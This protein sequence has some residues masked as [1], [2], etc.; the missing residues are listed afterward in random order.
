M[1]FIFKAAL[2][3]FSTFITF[4]S[5]QAAEN[6]VFK[7]KLIEPSNCTINNDQRIDIDFGAKISIA[8]IDGNNYREPIN[9]QITCTP[10]TVKPDMAMVIMATDMPSDN[11]A[12]QTDNYFLGI[13]LLQNTTPVILNQE[14]IFDPASP[15]VLEAVPVTSDQSALTEGRFFASATIKV[16]YR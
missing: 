10:G 2:L 14:I 6:M 8:M 4:A 9:Y 11:T 7:G 12:I 1:Q 3:L 15:P 16:E 5:V 13:R